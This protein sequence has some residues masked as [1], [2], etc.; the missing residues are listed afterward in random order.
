[1][2]S[3]RSHRRDVSSYDLRTST[4]CMNLTRTSEAPTLRSEP[5]SLIVQLTSFPADKAMVF[6]RALGCAE[7]ETQRF[8]VRSTL[9]RASSGPTAPQLPSPPRLLTARYRLPGEGGTAPAIMPAVSR[10]CGDPPMA[11]DL[12]CQQ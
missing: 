1:M 6:G 9:H 4:F 10:T 5:S 8:C 3:G 12:T 11:Y 2:P 7:K